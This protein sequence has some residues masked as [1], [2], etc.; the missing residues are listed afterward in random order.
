[1]NRAFIATVEGPPNRPTKDRFGLKGVV[2]NFLQEAE[3]RGPKVSGVRLRLFP[4]LPAP[5]MRR[6]ALLSAVARLALWRCV[7]QCAVRIHNWSVAAVHT[8]AGRMSG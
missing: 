2:L 5:S 4:R 1:M 3:A 8:A 7:G 6:A